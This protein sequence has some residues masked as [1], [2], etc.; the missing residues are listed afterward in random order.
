MRYKTAILCVVI[1]SLIIVI[2]G[3][4]C[5]TSGSN[6]AS[7]PTSDQ[8]SNSVKATP[9]PM[10]SGFSK[11]NPAPIGT[12]VQF[13]DGGIPGSV[14][15]ITCLEAKHGND[16]YNSMLST[17]D[18][19]F[20]KPYVMEPDD[21]NEYVIAKFRVEFVNY[22]MGDEPLS[23]TA[24]MSGFKCYTPDGIREYDAQWLSDT[25]KEPHLSEK[26]FKGDSTEGWV[27]F[28]VKQGYSNFLVSYNADR[29]WFSI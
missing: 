19:L 14:I 23:Y 28:E 2:S 5:F 9:T 7:T 25:Y 1:I 20:G 18:T 3:C 26:L 21:G 11:S 16:A 27:T 22:T 13:H 8:A 17:A 4:C 15:R 6:P 10:P 29:I 24:Y 12:T